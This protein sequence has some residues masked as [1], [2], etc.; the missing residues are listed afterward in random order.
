MKIGNKFFLVMSLFVLRTYVSAQEDSL[1][2]DELEAELD[3]AES[4]KE[5]STIRETLEKPKPKTDQA[6]T[7]SAEAAESDDTFD[8]DY[9]QALDEALEGDLQLA[10]PE[11]LEAVP[12]T[13]AELQTPPPKETQ[14]VQPKKEKTQTP[15]DLDIPPALRDEEMDIALDS[16]QDPSEVFS[17]IPLRDPLTDTNWRKFAGDSIDK[18]YRVRKKDTLWSV[19]ER[20]FGNPYLW[21]KVWQLNANLG[22]PHEID[23]R[24]EISFEPGQVNSAPALALKINESEV[25]PLYLVENDVPLTLVE[26]LDKILAY[27]NTYPHPAFQTFVVQNE[28]TV[29]ARIPEQPDDRDGTFYSE[30]DYFKVKDLAPGTYSIVDI[31]PLRGDRRGQQSGNNGYVV[32]WYGQAK[33]SSDQVATITKSFAEVEKGFVLIAENFWI[34][35]LQLRF[36]TVGSNKDLKTGL[37]TIQEG[38]LGGS[39][40]FQLLGVNFGSEEGPTPGALLTFKNNYEKIGT[41]LL[42]HRQGRF[43][44]ITVVESKKEVTSSVF[45]E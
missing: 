20:F 2:F 22:N 35:P 27:Q 3:S 33:V 37:I 17:K 23:T 38:A 12:G 24:M 30:N 36:E 44:T 11:E 45:L 40:Q 16:D 29:M 41:G 7:D 39:A 34:K 43:G 42:I 26:K 10:D 13:P 1:P 19:S 21:P 5:N 31:K 32:R 6:E 25:G 15:K 8:S 28:P 4:P 9:N 14:L 18:T